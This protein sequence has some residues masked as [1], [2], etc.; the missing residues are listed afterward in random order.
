MQ[1]ISIG[2]LEVTWRL[3]RRHPEYEPMPR[4]PWGMSWKNGHPWLQQFYQIAHTDVWTAKQGGWQTVRWSILLV[5]GIASVAKAFEVDSNNIIG[6]V[7]F[8]GLCVLV[9][10][11]NVAWVCSLKTFVV[12]SRQRSF[13]AIMAAF[14]GAGNDEKFAWALFNDKEY[15]CPGRETKYLVVQISVILIATILAMAVILAEITLR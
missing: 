2:P 13:R 9:A 4:L 7:T 1:V 5:G 12:E 15:L 14:G 6:C 8:G 10:L 3:Q 11:L